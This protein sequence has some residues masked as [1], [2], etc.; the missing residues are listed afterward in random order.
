M[1]Y[2]LSLIGFGLS[3]VTV[4]TTIYLLMTRKPNIREQS[5]LFMVGMNAVIC[6]AVLGMS[7]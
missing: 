3:C 4:S 2:T 1:I 7:L 5:F 6:S